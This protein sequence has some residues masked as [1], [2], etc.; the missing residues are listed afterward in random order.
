MR[1]EVPRY[2]GKRWRLRQERSTVRWN[3]GLLKGGQ[4][5]GSKVL[6]EPPHCG[7]SGGGE[8]IDAFE[9]FVHAFDF[10]AFAHAFGA[11]SEGLKFFA[12]LW[13]EF[14][15]GFRQRVFFAHDK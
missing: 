15:I 14:Y 9:Y 7:G 13:I 2:C 10:A 12:F 11:F 1:A 6:A 3:F 8:L 4:N 5:F